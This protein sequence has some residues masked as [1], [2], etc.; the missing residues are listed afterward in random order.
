MLAAQVEN[1]LNDSAHSLHKQLF[2]TVHYR[3]GRQAQPIGVTLC[4]RSSSLCPYVFNCCRYGRA[5][6]A[7]FHGFSVSRHILEVNLYVGSEFNSWDAFEQ[8]FR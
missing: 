5:K 6:V 3:R 1:N 4:F 8:L 7:A 2:R